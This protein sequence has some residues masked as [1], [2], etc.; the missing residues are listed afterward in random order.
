MRN[1]TLQVNG[2][3]IKKRIHV[4][5]EHVVPSRCREDFLKRRAMHE[6]LKKEA[7]QKGG[8]CRACGMHACSSSA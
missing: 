6:N 8:A 2:R 3:I 1:R 4:R 5:T 7:K